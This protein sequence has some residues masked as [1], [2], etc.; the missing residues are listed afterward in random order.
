MVSELLGGIR[1]L[2]KRPGNDIRKENLYPLVW[3][4]YNSGEKQKNTEVAFVR[5]LN[6]VP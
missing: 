5:E 4:V 3:V 6:W 1:Q 2:N